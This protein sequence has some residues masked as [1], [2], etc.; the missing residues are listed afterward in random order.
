M[1][2]LLSALTGL[3]AALALGCGGSDLTLPS[4]GRPATLAVV[5]GNGQT[6]SRGQMLAEPLVVRVTDGA[7]RP[8]AQIRVA[9]VVTTG[10]GTTNPD[11]ATTDADGRATSR[12][13]LGA[14]TGAQAV[15]ARVAGSDAV[16]A[17]FNGTASSTQT[18]PT[19]TT[20]QI[21][22]ATPTPSFPTQPVAVSV[23]VSSS[24]GSPTRHG[25]GYRRQ[26]ELHRSSAG[27][28]VQPGPAD[29]GL[30]DPHRPVYGIGDL[31][32]ELRHRQP[33][34]GSGTDLDHPLLQQQPVAQ[35]RRRDLHRFGDEQFQHARRIGPVGGG[36]LFQP[37]RTWGA[38][39]LDGDG[40][41]E[42]STR[43]L[44]PGTH[45]MIA[46]YLGNTTFA[47]SASDVLEQRVSKKG[48]D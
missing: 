36:Q 3:G 32:T 38:A 17:T 26:G 16:K 31:C 28:R 35:R 24:A 34:G 48:H 33:R 14:A 19:L 27:Q 5:D 29:R 20:T 40:Q 41:A 13:T 2:S 1:P 44:S 45:L 12:W 23:R 46:C 47:P 10:G 7:Q 11:T 39:G 22:S 8:V 9:F 15:E 30:E 6:G 21:T 4:E 43:S 25:D 37:T 42:L 18:G